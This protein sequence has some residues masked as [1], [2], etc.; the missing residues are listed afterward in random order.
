M[1]DAQLT[2][3]NNHQDTKNSK[4]EYITH[5]NFYIGSILHEST[6]VI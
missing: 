1:D 4:K 6:S 2:Y 5:K 3:L